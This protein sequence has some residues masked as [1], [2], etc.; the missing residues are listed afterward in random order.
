MPSPGCHGLAGIAG[1]PMPQPRVVNVQLN[2][3][4]LISFG[5][6]GIHILAEGDSW[7]AWSQLNLAPSSNILQQLDFDAPS[8]VVNYAYSGDTIRRMADFFRNGGFFIEMRSQKYDVILLSGGGNDVIDALYDYRGDTPLLLHPAATSATDDPRAYIDWARLHALSLYITANFRQIFRYRRHGPAANADTPIVLHTYD[9]PTPRNAPASFMGMPAAGPWLLPA[10]QKIGAPE[11]LYIPVT[12]LLFDA[13]AD[14]LLSLD[15]P[16]NG[17]HVVDT[18]GTIQPAELN[19]PGKSGDWINEIHP[20][21]EGY[22]H[23][24]WKIGLLLAQFGWQ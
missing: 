4:E 6:Y 23:L 20:T 7:F 5:D 10:L 24:A 9:Y 19:A 2:P 16:A 17:V 14:T 13:V 21:T 1:V 12:K 18:R 8:L 22:A 3:E 11:E 15:D